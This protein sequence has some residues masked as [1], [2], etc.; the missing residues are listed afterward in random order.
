MKPIFK[1]IGIG[2]L[3]VVTIFYATQLMAFREYAF[4]VSQIR[5][6]QI[7]HVS[8][9]NDEIKLSVVCQK[10]HQESCFLRAA[11]NWYE[12]DSANMNA[13]GAMAMALVQN[14]RIADSLPYFRAYTASGGHDRMVTP[15]FAKALSQLGQWDEAIPLY[16]QIFATELSNRELAADLLKALQQ[17]GHWAEA[18]SLRE[19][20]SGVKHWSAEVSAA[21]GL[22][23]ENSLMRE[24]RFP[25]LDGRT[26]LLPITM[27]NAPMFFL[28]A[29]P[30]QKVS[31]FNSAEL[32]R[33]SIRYE[34][35]SGGRIRLPEFQLGG[36]KVRGVEGNLCG[37]C[38]TVVGSDV[39]LKLAGR[40]D[41]RNKIAMLILSTETGEL[42]R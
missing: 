27:G 10:M 11:Q 30:D 18:M 3:A 4:F 2:A 38:T 32:A 22:A 35:I 31:A 14:N 12:K 23:S 5:L 15:Y 42:N 40:V 7:L 41:H 13:I 29:Q 6:R 36:L 26:F 24:E 28:P 21:R 9:L 8:N 19:Q 20:L 25:S 34:K 17:A 39:L 16:Y 1:T 37:D 33:W